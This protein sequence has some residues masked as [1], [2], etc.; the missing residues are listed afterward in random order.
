MT[1]VSYRGKSR[2]RCHGWGRTGDHHWLLL[3]EWELILGVTQAFKCFMPKSR[4]MQRKRCLQVCRDSSFRLVQL[5]LNWVSATEGEFTWY[6][7]PIR[8]PSLFSCPDFR[9]LRN[10]CRLWL[11][12]WPQ[13]LKYAPGFV[14]GLHI[15]T[16]LSVVFVIPSTAHLLLSEKSCSHSSSA[17]IAAP[18][19][20][21]GIPSHSVSTLIHLVFFLNPTLRMPLVLSVPAKYLC[22]SP[23][24]GLKWRQVAINGD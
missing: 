3:E 19:K 2:A 6:I 14:Q 8:D 20:R 23:V 15:E 10:L 16:L 21:Q 24:H 4:R 17:V 5:Q 9:Q 7:L 1:F 22:S 12:S 18:W 11:L 13:T